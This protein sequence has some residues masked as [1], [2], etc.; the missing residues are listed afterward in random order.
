MCSSH[1]TTLSKQGIIPGIS[2]HTCPLIFTSQRQLG[3][4]F[5]WFKPLC[6]TRK[7]KKTFDRDTVLS[8]RKNTLL[9]IFD[10]QSSLAL[11]TWAQH[12]WVCL[13][14]RRRNTFCNPVWKKPNSMCQLP[15]WSLTLKIIQPKHFKLS[16]TSQIIAWSAAFSLNQQPM[17]MF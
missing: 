1:Y 5:A 12:Y 17:G 15:E 2:I 11:Q 3:E 8:G 13:L 6:A 10:L 9:I 7:D 4:S 16:L 14:L